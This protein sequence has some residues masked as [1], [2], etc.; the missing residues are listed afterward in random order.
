VASGHLRVDDGNDGPPP[1]SEM[2]R[3]SDATATGNTSAG[4]QKLPKSNAFLAAG[5]IGFNAPRLATFWNY[6]TMSDHGFGAVNA[7]KQRKGETIMVNRPASHRNLRVPGRLL[8]VLALCLSPIASAQDRDRNGDR[9]RNRNSETFTVLERGTVIP[10]R[11]NEAIDVERS[12]NRIYTGIVDRD[13]RGDDGRLAIPRDSKVELIV[14]TTADNSLVIDLESVVANGERY[15][16]KTD[17]KRIESQRDD[18]L[19]GGI[20][21]AI[22]GG[23]VR[24]RAV[25]VPRDTVVTFRVQRALEMGVPD[26]G[27]MRDGRHYHDYDD[28]DDRDRSRQRDDRQR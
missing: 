28:R 20:V 1:S 19:I 10:V 5:A 24:G 17:A 7:G 6:W 11:T 25:R 27:S 2:A 26:R 16:I 3:K 9:D 8:V 12:D 23:E 4:K 18:S 15:A 21:G 22:S 13:V 14:R